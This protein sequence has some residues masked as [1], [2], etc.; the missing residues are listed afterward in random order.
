M[1]FAIHRISF[2]W[3]ILCAAT[4]LS[5]ESSLGDAAAAGTVI[6]AIGVTKAWLIGRE[7]MEL[8]HSALWLRALFYVW[9]GAVGALLIGIFN[10]Y[11]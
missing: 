9:V 11:T 5:F 10:F 1:A 4:L 2:I 3:A 6:I 8:R 7:F